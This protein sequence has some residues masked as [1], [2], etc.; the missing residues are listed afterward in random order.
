[1]DTNQKSK[2]KKQGRTSGG[3]TW[4]G[5]LEWGFDMVC[6]SRCNGKKVSL[7]EKQNKTQENRHGDR[8]VV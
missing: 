8:R 7:V 1:M 6:L 4:T 5:D 2:V 3:M